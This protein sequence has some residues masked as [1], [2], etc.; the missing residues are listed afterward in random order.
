MYIL[1]RIADNTI[2]GSANN[3]IDVKEASR[4]NRRVY[5]ID[6]ADFS[7]EMFGQQI[8]EYKVIE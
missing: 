2:V 3:P 1:V 6:D 4:Q 7:P 5:E 8:T